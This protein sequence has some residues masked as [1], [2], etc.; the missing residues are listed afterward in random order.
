MTKIDHEKMNRRERVWKY[1]RITIYDLESEKK[2]NQNKL[3]PSEKSLQDLYSELDYS[4]NVYTVAEEFRKFVWNPENFKTTR[5]FHNLQELNAKYKKKIVEIDIECPEPVIVGA[6]FRIYLRRQAREIWR[7]ETLASYWAEQSS[8]F[9]SPFDIFFED[10]N[11]VLQT[12]FNQLYKNYM[13]RVNEITI[14]EKERQKIK[15]RQDLL[16]RLKNGTKS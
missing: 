13:E 8:L 5:Q 3:S 9:I 12:D 15:D 11:K 10:A 14:Q 6:Y 1:P 4:L 2:S 7:N 16:N